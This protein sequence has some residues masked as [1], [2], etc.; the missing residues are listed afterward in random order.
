MDVK[1]A[2][3]L[4]FLVGTT[5]DELGGSHYT[6]VNNFDGGVSPKVDAASAKAT[7]AAIHRAIAGGLVAAC[8]DLSEGG[9]AAAAAE[10]AF[11]GGLGAELQLANVPTA[12]Q[13]AVEATL[14]SESNTR[15]L[16]EVSEDHAAAFEAD[17]A[18]IPHAHVGIVRD[19][20]RFIIAGGDQSTPLVDTTI[21]KLKQA[22]Q[23]PL[24]Y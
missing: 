16:C 7:F 9:L 14:F 12:G 1:Q 11:A 20:D 8:H 17:L 24:K 4:L 19:D 23:N 22:W 5:H 3:N 15:F 13:L 21:T 6:L 10:M 2:G 18:G